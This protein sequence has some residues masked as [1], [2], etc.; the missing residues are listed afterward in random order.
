MWIDVGTVAERSAAHFFFIKIEF[1]TE[2]TRSSSS[3]SYGS[4]GERLERSARMGAS[5]EAPLI[6]KSRLNMITERARELVRM[7]THVGAGAE[8]PLIFNRD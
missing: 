2:E 1:D 5:A 3:V 4:D 6:F 8:A 7:W